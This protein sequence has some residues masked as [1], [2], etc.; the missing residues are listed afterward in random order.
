[1]SFEFIQELSEARLFRN[2]AKMGEV[3]TSELADNFFNA[4]LALQTLKQT[5]PKAAQKYAQQTLQSGSVDGWR[6][7]GSD[8][9]N[10]AFMLKNQDRYEGRMTKDRHVTMPNLMFVG[11]LRNMAAG[12]D[13]KRYDR[14]FLLRLQKELAVQSPGLRA[15]RRLI[16]DWDH[17]LNDERKLAATRVHQGMRHNMQSSDMYA[18][19][20]KMVNKKGLLIKD[21]DEPRFKVPLAAKIAGAAV[22]GYFLGKKIASL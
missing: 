20:N 4:V 3:F 19:Y 9:H 18:P 15:A 14:T 2:P 1:M 8:L 13:D 6:S 22:G 10:M 11:W 12:R 7:S 17:A 5:D 21:A 16:A